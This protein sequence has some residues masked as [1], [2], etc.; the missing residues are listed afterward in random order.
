MD[1]MDMKKKAKGV[2]NL[3]SDATEA[4]RFAIYSTLIYEV[5]KCVIIQKTLGYYD[6][7]NGC[8]IMEQIIAE[9]DGLT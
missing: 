5:T 3:L 7:K 1:G 6:E 9:S 4:K 2:F 8:E